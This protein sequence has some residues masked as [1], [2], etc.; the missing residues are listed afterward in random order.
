MGPRGISRVVNQ[1]LAQR[2]RQ[3]FLPWTVAR[4]G[5]FSLFGNRGPSLDHHHA[6]GHGDPWDPSTW[7]SPLDSQ[8]IAYGMADPIPKPAWRYTNGDTPDFGSF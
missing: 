2:N 3:G 7:E 4:D 1:G 6:E 5:R 8:W